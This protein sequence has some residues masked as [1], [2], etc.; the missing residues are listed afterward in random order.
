M[1]LLLAAWIAAISVNEP[2]SLLPP[3]AVYD[4]AVPTPAS[5]LG[6]EVGDWHVRHDQV[7][8]YFQALE[9]AS[10]RVK[11]TRH[12]SSHEQRPL[13][14]AALSSPENLE[15]IGDLRDAH[16]Q[17]LRNDT[18]QEELPV[19][20][21]LG[22]SVHGN[23][24]SGTNAALLVAYHLAAGQGES[25]EKLLEESILLIDPCLNPDGLGRFAQWANSHRGNQLVGDPQHREHREVWPGG[26]TNHYWFDLNRDWLLLTQPESRGR[27]RRFHQWKPHVLADFH[28]MGSDSTYF[29]QPGVPSRQNP[30][31]P[32]DNL[33]LTR[34]V[35]EYHARALDEQGH[36]YYTE[37]TFDDFYYGKGS[38]YPDVSGCIG[39]LFEQ[40]SARGQL[41]ETSYGD[42]RFRFAIRNQFLTSLST[43]R[44]AHELRSELQEYQREFFRTALEE[45]QRDEVGAYVFQCGD[46]SRL[47]HFLDVLHQHHLLV[48]PLTEDLTLGDRRFEAGRAFAVPLTQP[49]ARLVKAVFE[50]RTEFRDSVF[51]DVSSWTLPLS[52]GIPFAPWPASEYRRE[53][54]GD[55]VEGMPLPTGTPLEN[56]DAYAYLLPWTEDLAP[57]GL[58][59]LLRANVKVRVAT[60]PF[61]ARTESGDQ[62]FEP[63]T[64]VIPAGLQDAADDD[65]KVV[66]QSLSVEDGLTVSAVSTGLTDDGIDLGSPNVREVRRPRVALIV[67]RGVSGYEAGEVWH[68]LDHRY[69]VDVTLLESDRWMQVDESPLTHVILVSGGGQAL[70]PAGIE[71]LNEWAERGG[72][73]VA[74]RGSVP[75]SERHL[76]GRERD[77]DKEDLDQ[78][79]AESEE[80]EPTRLA[81][82]DYEQWMARRRISGAIFAAEL[83]RT[84]P[85]GF[86]FQEDRVAVFRNSTIIMDR[87]EDLFANVLVYEDEPLLG[88]FVSPENLE[89]VQQS[90]VVTAVRLGAGVLIRLVDNPNFRGTWL[91]TNKLMANSLFFSSAIR[92]TSASRDR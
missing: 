65:W 56:T 42:L 32:P 67:G 82:A 17:A 49:E 29:F 18:S 64:L 52:Y 92:D 33:T 71:K 54:L 21:W 77:E 39:I 11:L 25:I 74:I 19:I 12:G 4:P 7:V 55:P 48:C 3:E 62:S 78:A 66:L 46:S 76:L 70:S 87:E 41:T 27:V 44:A 73:V 61:R 47:H 10:S 15:R 31:T 72:T 22:Y 26:R 28:E 45:A 40:A 35:A 85:L 69:A 8:Q 1:N 91:G 6:Y 38:T 57:R 86:G 90:A 36:L 30:L 58:Q 14:L 2:E 5:V 68:L 16:R 60:R 23:E 20:V 34:R 81:Y 43:L 80:P 9:R 50:Q 51:Y 13:L 37:E 63:G 53:I 75:W 59:R 24:A 84:H 79:D 88:G 89:K 83:D